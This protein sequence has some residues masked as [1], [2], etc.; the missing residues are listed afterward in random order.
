LVQ[1]VGEAWEVAEA[2]AGLDDR[3]WVA[4]DPDAGV[5]GER[6]EAAQQVQLLGLGEVEADQ[7]A[8]AGPLE[9]GCSPLGVG[10]QLPEPC[11]GRLGVGGELLGG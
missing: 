5:G 2:V 1:A 7:A 3:H 4:L 9:P 8:G 11:G 10:G 6:A